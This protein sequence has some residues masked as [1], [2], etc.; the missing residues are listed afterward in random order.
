MAH[1]LSWLG[2]IYAVRMT[3][4]PHLLYYF[5]SL[6]IAL[7]KSDLVRYQ[8]KVICFMWRGKNHRVSKQ[9][10]FA[11]K[12][13]GGLGLPLLLLYY[14]AAQVAR[15]SVAYS[16]GEKPK[17]VA[18]EKTVTNRIPINYLKWQPGRDRPPFLVPTLYNSLAVWDKVRHNPNLI[19]PFSPLAHLFNNPAFPPGRDP[20]AFHWWLN[21]VLFCIGHFLTP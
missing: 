19:S 4:L 2:K 17:K 11:H 3:L 8:S 12:M 9:V 10:L 1:G 21:K 15:L 16:W 13:K 5:R 14:Q 20:K 7:V 6:P 18:M